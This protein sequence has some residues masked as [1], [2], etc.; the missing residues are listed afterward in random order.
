MRELYEYLNSFLG[1]TYEVSYQ[2]LQ[3]DTPNQL[4][5]FLYQGKE[6]EEDLTGAQIYECVNVHL[7]LVCEKDENAIFDGLDY[8]SNVVDNLEWNADGNEEVQIVSIRRL[9]KKA[10]PIG[11]NEHGYPEL[12]S[13]LQVLYILTPAED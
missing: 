3:E 12:V 2:M 9:G 6:D 4:G 5:L 1:D 7:Q 8:L 11:Q 10:L 13:N